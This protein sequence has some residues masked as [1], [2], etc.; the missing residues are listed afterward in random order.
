MYALTASHNDCTR[1]APCSPSPY[2]PARR[3]STQAHLVSTLPASLLTLR[4]AA[5]MWRHGPAVGRAQPGSDG[6]WD[7]EKRAE[8]GEASSPAAYSPRLSSGARDPPPQ[9]WHLHPSRSRQSLYRHRLVRQEYAE[10]MIFYSP[11]TLG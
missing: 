10:C 7:P 8:V 1:W 6:A 4:V 9:L 3:C 11:T 5:M 2:N